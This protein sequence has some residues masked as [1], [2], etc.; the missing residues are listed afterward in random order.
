[1]KT[2]ILTNLPGID[3]AILH[4][5]PINPDENPVRY[6]VTGHTIP[7]VEMTADEVMTRFGRGI[8]NYGHGYLTLI[9]KDDAHVELSADVRHGTHGFRANRY[10]LVNPANQK[11]QWDGWPLFFESLDQAIELFAHPVDSTHYEE[12][13]RAARLRF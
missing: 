2:Q 13:K 5:K 11:R 4:L 10:E 8:Y 9:A 7:T 3:D 12:G 1:M 6:K